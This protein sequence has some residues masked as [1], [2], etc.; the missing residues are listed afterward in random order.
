MLNSV[1]H[2]SL[3]VLKSKTIS[4]SLLK[5]LL[6]NIQ[7]TILLFKNSILYYMDHID[8]QKIKILFYS[9]YANDIF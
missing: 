6:K 5:I 2:Y 8:V 9:N 3:D 4:K 1:F 7:L